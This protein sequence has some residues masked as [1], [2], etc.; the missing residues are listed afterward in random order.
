MSFILMC[1]GRMNALKGLLVASITCETSL[2]LIS[3]LHLVVNLAILSMQK[4]I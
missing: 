3:M 1:K 2:I 4:S